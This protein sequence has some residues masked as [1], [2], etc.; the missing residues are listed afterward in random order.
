MSKEKTYSGIAASGGIAIGRAYLYTKKQVSVNTGII[1]EKEI[2]K[3]ISELENAIEISL[4]ELNKVYKISIEKIGEKNSKIFEAQIE[5]LKDRIF[6]EKVEQRIKTDRRN[7]GYIFGDEIDKLGAVFLKSKNGYLKER[8]TD[9]M[10]VKNRVLRNMKREKLVSKIEENSVIFAHELT[11]ADTIL[12]SRRKVLGYAT[13]TGGITSHA[14]IISRALRIPAVVGMKIVTKHI[15]TGDFVIID[16]FEGVVI[17]N[18]SEE[19]FKRYLE[20]QNKYKE[21][22]LV[23]SSIMDLPCET[24]DGKGV[25]VTAN[26]EFEEEADF[27]KNCGNCGIGLFRTEYLVLEKGTFPSEAEQIEEYSH[28]ASVTFPETVTIRTFDVGADKILDE[29]HKETNP[30]LGWR[31]IRVSLDDIKMFKDQLKALLVSSVKK[32]IKIMLPMISSI[33]EV[34][35]SREILEECKK[36][37]EEE[38]RFFDRDIQLGI[39]IEVPSA[40]MLAEELAKEAD[41]FSIGTNDLTQYILAVDRGN[42][43]ISNLFRHFHPAVIRALKIIIDAG[44]KENIKVSICGDMASV[45]VAVPVLV[46]LGI[47]ELSVM[48]SVYPEI[49]QIIRILNCS[50]AKTFSESLIGLS[51]ETEVREKAEKFFNENIK[52]KLL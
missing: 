38:K 51:T 24:A 2:E 11:P 26:I 18:P 4:K 52:T 32:N 44:H 49:K 37:L 31:G 19:T 10:D 34:R 33:E 25:K 8:F 47:D 30:N 7:A 13:E 1:E 12:F 27:I 17:V 40:F 14:A 45:P 5:I 3:E 6:L 35:K 22:E 48:P 36:E 20:K 50:E 16:G 15:A 41:F 9:L 42:E 29:G 43:R 39:M 46:G 28:I 23:L 21:H